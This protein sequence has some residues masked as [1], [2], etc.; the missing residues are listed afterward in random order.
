MADET[1]GMDV[2]IAEILGT[3]SELDFGEA[4]QRF[5]EYLQQH[6]EMPCEVT[7]SEDFRWEEFY[8]FGPGDEAEYAELRRTQPSFQ[9]RYELLSIELAGSSR[10]MLFSDDIMANCRRASDGREFQL[11]LSELEATRQSSANY[12]LLLDYSTWFVNSR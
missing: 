12:Q 3:D 8:V 7:G 2:R 10:W 11:G 6:L 1:E 4:R 9:D 5:F